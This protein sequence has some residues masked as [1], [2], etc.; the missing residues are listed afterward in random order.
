MIREMTRVQVDD[1]Q[2][3]NVLELES[4]RDMKLLFRSRDTVSSRTM[5]A[6]VADL[7]D[8]VAAGG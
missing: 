6:A 5:H 3:Y 2:E 1:V 4:H 8:R 7:Q